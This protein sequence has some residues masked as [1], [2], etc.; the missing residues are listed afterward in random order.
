VGHGNLLDVLEAALALTLIIVGF[1]L[2][3]QSVIGKRLTSGWIVR[4]GDP[5]PV[6]PPEP[7]ET[8]DSE[9]EPE[10][11]EPSTPPRIVPPQWYHRLYTLI[12]GVALTSLGTIVL[13]LLF[14][15]S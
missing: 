5:P 10:A 11:H 13:W 1:G 4:A 15:N 12:L 9:G 8:A 7:D 14:F 6:P 3:R 2:A